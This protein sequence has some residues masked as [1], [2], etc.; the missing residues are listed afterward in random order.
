MFRSGFRT[1]EPSGRSRGRATPCSTLPLLSSPPTASRPW[2]ASP[3]S[4]PPGLQTVTQV[5]TN[6]SLTSPAISLS[7]GLSQLTQTFGGGGG[8]SG[9]CP[10]QNS[11]GGYGGGGGGGGGG[12]G[13]PG[14]GQHGPPTWIHDREVHNLIENVAKGLTFK[15]NQ[16]LLQKC[17]DI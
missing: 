7:S 1:E 4:P 16:F 2:V 9:S 10:G 12:Q 17:C 11:Y 3:P 6:L 15:Y 8:F 13:Q 14:G 5:S